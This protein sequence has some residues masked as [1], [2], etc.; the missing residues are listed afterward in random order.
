MFKLLKS[1][2]FHSFEEEKK[3]QKCNVTI[4]N[5]LSSVSPVQNVLSVPVASV[6]FLLSCWSLVFFFVHSH[7]CSVLPLKTI[8]RK[9]DFKIL[10][11]TAVLSLL[12]SGCVC[13]CVCSTQNS[14]SRVQYTPKRFSRQK[15]KKNKRPTKKRKIKIVQILRYMSNERLCGAPLMLL[16]W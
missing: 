6:S 2:I 15:H 9:C 4:S 5:Q 11:E 12:K 16:Q 1:R 8:F 7:V 13:V 3:L 14:F 10:H